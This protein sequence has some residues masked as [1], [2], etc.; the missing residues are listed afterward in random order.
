M[1]T[2]VNKTRLVALG[3]CT[4]AGCGGCNGIH[5]SDEALGAAQVA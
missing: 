1:V 3:G 5:V 2:L 4:P